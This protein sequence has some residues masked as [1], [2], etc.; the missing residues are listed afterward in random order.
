VGKDHAQHPTIFLNVTSLK[1]TFGVIDSA[2]GPID[3]SLLQGLSD[4]LTPIIT[5]AIDDSIKN[6]FIIPVHKGLGLTNDVIVMANGVSHSYRRLNIYHI[7]ADV[8][9]G[10]VRY[11]MIV[12]WCRS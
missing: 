2:V 12:P 6:G 8:V 3:L 1:L 10:I 9:L 11:D 5:K 7:I 4:M